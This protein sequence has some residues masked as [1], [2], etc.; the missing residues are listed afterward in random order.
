MHIDLNDLIS[1]IIGVL[2]IINW[3]VAFFVVFQERKNPSTIWAWLMM[4]AFIPAFGW[5]VYLI[6]G[7]EGRKH[8]RFALKAARDEKMFESFIEKNLRGLKK[9]LKIMESD[10]I[11]PIPNTSY[12][13]NVV[14]MNIKSGGSAYQSNNAVKLYSEGVSKF[15]DLLED[16]KNAKSFIHLQYYIVRDDE[17]G[18]RLM[19]ALAQKAAQ[20]VEVK[21]LYDGMGNVF[22]SLSFNKPLKEAGGEVQLFLPPRGIRI[23]YRNHRKLAIIDGKIGYIGGLNVGDEY[24][25]KVKRFGFWRDTHLRITGDCVQSMELRFMMDWNDTK[26]SKLKPE[27][28]YFPKPEKQHEQVTMQIVSSGPDTRWNNIQFGYFKMMTEANK[29]IYITTPY[30]VPDVSIL[31]ALKTAALSGVDVRIIIPAKPD[32]PFVYWSSLSYLGELLDA[33]VRCYEYTKGFIHS[34]VMSMD[35]IISSV[36]TANMDIRSF[37]LN[38][39]VNAFIYDKRVTGEIE[40]QFML[41]FNDC[42]EITKQSYASRS[43]FTRIR[44]SF[45][46]LISPL[47]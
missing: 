41:D 34:K 30:F 7:F 17:L 44:E 25:G 2:V 21:F 1:L 8:K 40:K 14:V 23:N 16:I 47:L 32:H 20:G 12:L 13:N 35:G 18:K 9:Q 6:F 24:L 15:N 36:G 31:E 37:E 26:G 45:A 10:N 43:R 29:N 27:D 4:L 39:E 22:N 33:G 11:L 5:I 3:G 46:R 38:F 28:K 19:S 42:R